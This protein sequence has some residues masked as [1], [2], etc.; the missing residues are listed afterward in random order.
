MHFLKRDRVEAVVRG[1]GGRWR[2][3]VRPFDNPA[4]LPNQTSRWCQPSTAVGTNTYSPSA[5]GNVKAR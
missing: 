4:L 3:V 1:S 5:G 2:F